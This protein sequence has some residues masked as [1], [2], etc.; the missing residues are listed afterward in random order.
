[1]AAPG[2]GAGRRDELKILTVE[3]RELRTTHGYNN[4]T[5]GAVAE[6]QPG[7]TPQETLAALQAWIAGQFDDETERI[8]LRERVSDLEWQ[9]ENLQRKVALVERKWKAFTDFL[10][11]LGIERPEEIPD[12]LKDLPF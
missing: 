10:A 9:E 7:Q 3:Y 2:C 6:V 11:R 4:K 5:I 1:M 12:D 8:R